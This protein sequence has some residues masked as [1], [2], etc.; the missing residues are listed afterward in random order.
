M[1]TRVQ[2][3]GNSLAVRIPKAL[4]EET[5]LQPGDE[6]E[7]TLQAGQIILTPKQVKTYTLDELLE[8]VTPE[9][10]PGEWDTGPTVGRES[11]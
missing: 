4:A 1:K 8:G 5:G 9:N 2:R 3:R 10:R 6:I 7:I 11:W